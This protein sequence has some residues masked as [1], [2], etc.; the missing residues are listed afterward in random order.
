MIYY[1]EPKDENLLVIVAVEG[2][3]KAH[4]MQE[5]EVFDLFSKYKINKLIRKNY[6]ALHT[7]DLDETIDFAEDVLKRLIA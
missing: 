1:D 2:Y 5:K 3:A 4:N 6:S 7:Q